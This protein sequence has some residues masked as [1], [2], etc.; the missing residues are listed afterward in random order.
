MR[1]LRKR[2][3]ATDVEIHLDDLLEPYSSDRVPAADHQAISAVRC[4]RCS[5]TIVFAYRT[6]PGAC[7]WCEYEL[8]I[9]F[10]KEDRLSRSRD[11]RRARRR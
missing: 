1:L 3:E 4:D 9:D 2:P 8:R 10:E 5:K 7:P 11:L 6:G